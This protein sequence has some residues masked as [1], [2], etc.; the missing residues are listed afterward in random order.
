MENIASDT[1][2]SNVDNYLVKRLYILD[3]VTLMF[4]SNVDFQF[5]QQQTQKMVILRVDQ[6]RRLNENL[7]FSLHA[8]TFHTQY[9]TE[10]IKQNQVFV[11]VV[12]VP[13]L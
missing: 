1:L 11:V 4:N 9:T 5:K 6:K 8:F 12:V 2:E 7:N 13:L 3:T 10:S